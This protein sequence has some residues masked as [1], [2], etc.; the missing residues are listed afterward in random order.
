MS[1]IRVGRGL[2]TIALQL[3]SAP[4]HAR[5]D[6]D[7]CDGIDNF[8]HREDGKGRNQQ[9]AE[10]GAEAGGQQTRSQAA[11]AGGDQNRRDE[12]QIRGI[13]LQNRGERDACD[14]SDSHRE[15]SD[16]VPQHILPHQDPALDAAQQARVA[17]F[18]GEIRKK[19]LHD[20]PVGLSISHVGTSLRDNIGVSS[21]VA[22]RLPIKPRR[23]L[24]HAGA[25]HEPRVSPVP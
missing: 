9:E 19:S 1:V 8:G 15:R 22:R 7:E 14:E 18:G 24:S 11:E 25:G 17:R 20:R 4:R 16:P 3:L 6:Q 2:H 5:S 12:E 13:P 23:S 21:L 10:H